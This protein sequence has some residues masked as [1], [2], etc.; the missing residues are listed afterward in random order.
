MAFEYNR[1]DKRRLEIVFGPGAT[2]DYKT[3]GTESFVELTID[4][5]KILLDEGFIDPDGRYNEAPTTMDFYA[6]MERHP[7]ITAHGYLV[8]PGRDD[9]R[10]VI[11]GL[12]YLGDPSREFIIDFLDTF[13]DADEIFMDEDGLYCW[14]G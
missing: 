9:Y 13:K 2:C 8:S 4:E 11:D 7:D 12:D 6:F 14:Y 10:M 3:G 1:D 5:L